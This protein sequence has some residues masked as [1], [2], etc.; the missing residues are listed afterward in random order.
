MT[1]T[2]QQGIVKIET[3][4]EDEVNAVGTRVEQIWQA[5]KPSLKQL[6]LTEL[7]MIEQAGLAYAESGFTNLAGA[8]ASV[9]SQLPTVEKEVEAIITAAIATT[10]ISKVADGTVVAA[11]S[12][13]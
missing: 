8:V 13:I 7:S 1:T 12:N 4:L 5:A 10:G 6:G 3:F 11:A 2:I 9:V